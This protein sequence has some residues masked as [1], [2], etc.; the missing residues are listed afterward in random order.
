MEDEH[1]HDRL[2]AV[3]GQASAMAT[4][5]SRCP[6]CRA[7]ITRVA[8]ADHLEDEHPGPLVE[9]HEP[10]DLTAAE[11]VKADAD[12][13]IV[14]LRGL[15]EER[16]DTALGRRCEGWAEVLGHVSNEAKRM[17]GAQ[18]SEA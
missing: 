6:V 2:L 17:I 9:A 4:E 16:P 1:I 8:L 18:R 5:E 10:V 12:K 13:L 7:V 11:Q 14:S 15:A 3:L